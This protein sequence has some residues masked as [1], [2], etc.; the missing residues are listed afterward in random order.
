[1]DN[2]IKV[3][4]KEN[5]GLSDAR[6]FGMREATGKY[7][8]FIDSD[9][10]IELDTIELLYNTIKE[11]K[12]DISMCSYY[13]LKNDNKTSD[14]TYKTY[15]FNREQI[16]QEILLDERVR[17][18]AW[19]KLFK[20]DLLKNIE[21]PKG[22]VFEDILTIPKI[23]E[24]VS[25][26]VWVDIP[27]YYYRQREGSILHKQTNELRL[28]YINA[29]LEINEYLKKKEKK[30]DI[31]CKYNIVHIAIKTYNDIGFFNMKELEKNE[32]IIELYNKAKE[33]F[34]NREVERFIIDNSNYVKKLHLYYLFTDKEGYLINNR[35]LPVIYTE[36][37]EMK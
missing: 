1:M 2:R 10:F 23:F 21:F 14:A 3:I 17:A 9:D 28:S 5:G 19:N 22:R 13:I 20:I 37:N 15:V 31:F 36:Y 11:N 35:K 26:V 27:K 12:C 18:Y 25:S 24:K 4:H 6:N 32:I 29:A 8:Q 7:I 33:I 16:L 30:L 34:E